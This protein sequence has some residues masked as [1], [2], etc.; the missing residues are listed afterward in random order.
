[1]AIA[2]L[3]G[4]CGLDNIINLVCSIIGK[5]SKGQSLNCEF[6]CLLFSGYAQLPMTSPLPS[7]CMSQL[8]L[9]H[10]N[11]KVK[12][13]SGCEGGWGEPGSRENKCACMCT[14]ITCMQPAL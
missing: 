9:L 11:L 4:L 1:M 2:T 12:G 13:I 14:Q 6:L 7:Q 8:S 3:K 10:R 5:G